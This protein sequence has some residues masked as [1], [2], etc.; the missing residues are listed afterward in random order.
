MVGDCY[1]GTDFVAQTSLKHIDF[2]SFH[3][4][5]DAWGHG[6]DAVAF[7]NAWIANHTAL[8]DAIGK[9]LVLGEFGAKNEQATTYAAWTS[10]MLDG[11]IAGDLFWMLCGRQDY[12]SPWYPNYDGFCVYCPNASDPAPPGGDTQSCGVLAAH[13]A[14]MAAA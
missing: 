6:Q 13:A 1:V 10:A 5:P 14:A 3:L 9:P 2:A 7:G 4:Y 12:S 8:A 11:G